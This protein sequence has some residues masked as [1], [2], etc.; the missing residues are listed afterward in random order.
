MI[1]LLI[2][3]GAKVPDIL[4]WAPAY[5]FE[6]LEGATYI[7]EK[8]MNP[9]TMSWQHVT[10]LHNIAQKG[11]LD[12]AALL[13]KYGA[14]INPIY[15]AYQSTPLDLA[16]RWGRIEMVKYLLQQGADVNKAGALW[17][18]PL[19]WAKKKAHVEVENALKKSGAK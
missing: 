9:N 3:Y 11:F 2:S 1:D 7:M 14:D 12:K 16:A 18:T 4:K 10:I 5:Y 8:G 15:E 6:R 13:I 19:A 17:S